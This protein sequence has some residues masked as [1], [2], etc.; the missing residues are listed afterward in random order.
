[1]NVFN[2]GELKVKAVATTPASAAFS[3]PASTGRGRS[4]PGGAGGSP[5]VTFAGEETYP[6]SARVAGGVQVPG[7]PASAP[8]GAAG[9]RSCLQ[10]DTVVEA[11]TIRE[12]SSDFLNWA[13]HAGGS[14]S[15]WNTLH[16]SDWFEPLSTR[17]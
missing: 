14:G 1:M 6:R 16:D 4:A 7:R 11:S 12:E 9:A 8:R 3:R 13:M 2:D 17:C 10:L 5:G 15:K